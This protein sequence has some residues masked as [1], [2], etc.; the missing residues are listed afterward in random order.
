MLLAGSSVAEGKAMIDRGVAADSSFPSGTAYLL[1]TSDRARNARAARYGLAT[2]LDV[3]VHV[4][5]VDADALRDRRDVLFYFTGLT[6][7]AGLETLH[8]LP[9][10]IAD[11]LTSTGGVLDRA[12]PDERAALARGGRDRQLRRGRSSR[13][14]SPRSSRSRRW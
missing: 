6:K 10:A 12:G 5:R 13:A 11:H 8:F 1:S 7:V 2:A 3:P 9:G 14:T 4:R